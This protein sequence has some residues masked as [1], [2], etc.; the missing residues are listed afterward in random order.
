VL[1]AIDSVNRE[2]GATTLVITHN[3]AIADIADRV[4]LFANGRI[5]KTEAKARRRKPS[6]LSW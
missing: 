1:E 2:L 5:V 6:E 4:L 3:V